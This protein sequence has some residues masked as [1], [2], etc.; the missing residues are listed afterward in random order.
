MQESIYSKNIKA[1]NRT[2][3]FD[4]R[5]IKSGEKYIHVTESRQEN[6]EWIRNNIVIFHDHV[7]EFFK[8]LDEIKRNDP[9]YPHPRFQPYGTFRYPR[10]A[11]R[12]PKRL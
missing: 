12:G 2:Y 3:F 4:I 11:C 9:K 10:N 1:G 5:K 8:I 6:G 7:D